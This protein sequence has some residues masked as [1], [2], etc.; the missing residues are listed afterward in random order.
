[1][2]A[3]VTAL[4]DARTEA[5]KALQTAQASAAEQKQ[6]AEQ[7]RQRG[8]VLAHQ[9]ASAREDLGTL[10]ARVT[11]LTDARSEAEKALQTAQAS[12]AEQKL[13][14]EQ[15]RQRGDAL[16]RQLASREPVAESLQN[17]GAVSR[18][19]AGQAV[20]MTNSSLQAGSVSPST[21]RSV[22]V[23]GAAPDG[24]GSASDQQHS[25]A[26]SVG[27]G[28]S[29]AASVREPQDAALGDPAASPSR[30][31]REHQIALWV[32][33]GE[34]FIAVGD[35]VSARLMFQRAA[36]KGSAKAAFMLAE[37]YDPAALDTS[38]PWVWRR[39]LQRRACGTRRP[40]ISGH[41]KRCE[42]S[43]FPKRPQTLRMLPSQTPIHQVPS[44]RCRPEGRMK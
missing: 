25:A 38:A 29:A 37:T 42:S 40:R 15:E 3:R 6:A 14:L 16:L 34:E 20:Q 44:G 8:E 19:D 26:G 27:K 4:T 11:A 9:L 1:M 12:A 39:T 23:E 21:T 43:K 18:I 32:K 30:A 13:A 2:T 7:E 10:T 5:E 24:P 28:H 33:R 22:L 17:G 36:E 35:F 31:I 41:P